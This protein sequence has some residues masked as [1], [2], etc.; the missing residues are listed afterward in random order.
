[1]F[2]II[3][4]SRNQPYLVIVTAKYGT[5]WP[6]VVFVAAFFF[7]PE[8]IMKP[9]LCFCLVILAVWPLVAQT[10][11]PTSVETSAAKSATPLETHRSSLIAHHSTRAVVV[12]ISDY[13][14]PVIPDLRFADRDA[15][16]FADWLR[17]PAG[18][19]V[20]ESHLQVLLNSDATAGKIIAA[21]GSLVTDCKPG[22][23]AVIYF[24]GHGDVERISKFQRGFWLS[25]DSPPAVY[26]AGGTCAL[27]YL[28]D[29]ISTLS[30]AGVQVVVVADACRAGKLAGSAVGGTQASSAA[31]AQQFAN[32]VK[33]L[34]CQPEEFSLEGEQ[35][36]G[37]RGA[38]SFHLVDA[39][40]GMADANTDGTVNLLE[41]GR[42]LED[43]VPAEAAPHS[44]IP[45]TVGSKATPVARVDAAQLAQWKK[46]KATAAP[47]FAKIDSK[48]LEELAL[49]DADSSVQA[50][51]RA[52]TAALKRGDLLEARDGVSPTADTLY[53]QLIREPALAELH[54]LMT[55]NFAAALMDEGQQ[56]LNR[57]LSGD[58]QA[59]EILENA[60]GINHRLLADQ[61]YRAAEL[62]GEK[63][64]Y[65]PSLK[66][67]GLYFEAYAVHNLDISY[68]SAVFLDFKLMREAVALDST[69][70]HIWLK[71]CRR[72]PSPD[73]TAYYIGRL[74]NLVPNWTIMHYT[75]GN[76]HFAVSP[77]KPE[78]ALAYYERALALDSTFAPAL[79]EMQ[80]PLT[81]LGRNEDANNCR[82]K[83]LRI[84][85]KKMETTPQLI[86]E[87]EW[88]VL[89]T[90]LFKLGRK[91]DFER[92]GR[93]YIAV[94]STSILRWESYATLLGNH[95][96]HS[97]AEQAYRKI[98]AL[99]SSESRGWY[100]VGW[101]YARL[102]RY[103]DMEQMFQKC[104]ALAPKDY[105]GWN[106]L[107]WALFYQ[108][109]YDDAERA[110]LQCLSGT[111]R[112][113]AA[114]NGLGFTYLGQK[115]YPE[116][117]HARKRYTEL[118]PYY[119]YGWSTLGQVLSEAGNFPEAEAA[120]R[121]A[122]QL[123]SANIGTY[124][125]LSLV[126]NRAGKY[127]EMAAVCRQAIAL[128]STNA[129]AWSNLGFG[130]LQTGQ[131]AEA[132]ATL[133]RAIALNP[134]SANARKHLGTL[135]FRTGRR[136]EARTGFE[137]AVELNPNYFGGYLGR[138]YLLAA[139]KKTT[140]ALAQVELAIQKNAIFEQLE[141]DTD[142]A[143][144]RALPEWTALMKKHF[145]D[146]V[147]D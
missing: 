63:H 134:K 66:S 81:R 54:G 139:E 119:P 86:A 127:A 85:L 38:F 7:Q 16:A 95:D 50:L 107:G 77:E 83:A 110:F 126:L 91:D 129:T 37:G 135:H 41:L 140:E 88:K 82:E 15:A 22:D 19:S 122:I 121:K 102:K 70:S 112:S 128:D 56:I 125:S 76:I 68:D 14:N 23:Q 123:D 130:L 21:L 62:L 26:A 42:Y 116:A 11:K 33:I 105:K 136:E 6:L 104:V 45:F 90:S 34:S 3:L 133:L 58:L 32:E 75:I 74:E 57:Y 98:I 94:D 143:P 146:K 65:Y 55:R 103:S 61:F 64:Y 47:Q 73:S 13:Q 106:G 2:E 99:D 39:L 69:A 17:S 1:L 27:G 87:E 131:H 59:F 46:Q 5:I 43:R 96:F 147:K 36:G 28:Q 114:W 97:E 20:P 108:K 49:A 10:G 111:K 89:G 124:N 44:Q 93:A 109:K 53:R 144:L 79:Y 12:G 31:L 4:I 48:G 80:F 35:W 18:G 84:G 137:K 40:Y 101:V 67:K 132:E 78:K 51:Y 24:S 30:D 100:G 115:R 29:I 117:I 52:F 71:L 72:E 138:A 9:I 120:Y 118:L 145:P 92:A 25:W 142:L 113:L 141:Q 8:Q 60:I